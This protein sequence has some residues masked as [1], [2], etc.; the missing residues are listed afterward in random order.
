MQAMELFPSGLSRKVTRVRIGSMTIRVARMPA[1]R[2]GSRSPS[3]RPTRSLPE[4]RALGSVIS[5]PCRPGRP[6]CSELAL[7][8]RALRQQLLIRN[9]IAVALFRDLNETPKPPRSRA[10]GRVGRGLWRRPRWLP[11]GDRDPG[12]GAGRHPRAPRLG[13]RVQCR[14]GRRSRTRR[15]RRAS[16]PRSRPSSRASAPGRGQDPG[17]VATPRRSAR[18]LSPGCR[19]IA[20]AHSRDGRRERGAASRSRAGCGSRTHVGSGHWRAGTR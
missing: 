13:R 16:W 4:I 7:G 14:G 12:A 1:R 8:D 18:R 5:E 19:R 9:L 15:R 20:G 6:Q 2:P 10:A 3:S 11:R 17:S